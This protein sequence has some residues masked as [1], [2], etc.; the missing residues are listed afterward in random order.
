MRHRRPKVLYRRGVP[1]PR[2]LIVN[3]AHSVTT[4]APPKF[5]SELS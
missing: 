5:D 4:V 3:G 2:T 1:T